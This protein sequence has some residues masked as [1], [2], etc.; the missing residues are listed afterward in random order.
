MRQK[1]CL[2]NEK[3]VAY[4]TYRCLPRLLYSKKSKSLV[5]PPRLRPETLYRN[6]LLQCLWI[7]L[8]YLAYSHF[9][10]YIGTSIL[11]YY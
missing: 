3:H 6:L 2:C 7:N 1:K 5:Q 11:F 9:D 10:I 4:W 8:V